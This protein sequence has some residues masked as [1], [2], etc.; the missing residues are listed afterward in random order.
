MD[1]FKENNITSIKQALTCKE[2]WSF[3]NGISLCY[4]CHKNL[5]KLRTKMKN[6]FLI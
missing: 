5:E 1:I 2:V 3:N 6:M 4:N